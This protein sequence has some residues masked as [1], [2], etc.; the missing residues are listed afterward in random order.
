MNSGLIRLATLLLIL[1]SGADAR[2][3]TGD[4]Y[5]A[6]SIV[7]NQSDQYRGTED[8]LSGIQVSG[9]R[10]MSDHL[11]LEALLGY[12][13]L[14][15][16]CEPG[17]CYPDQKILEASA[18]ALFFWNRKSVLA[19]Y[20]LIGV[21]YQTIGADS[22][23]QYAR[24]AGDGGGSTSLALGLKWRLRGGSYSLRLEQRVRLVF[25]TANLTDT[26]TT[27]GVQYDF[28]RQRPVVAP[29]ANN[30]FIADKDGDFD[31]IPD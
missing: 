12:S 30:D 26:L 3:Q 2:A 23:P 7:F 1:A 16:L 4:W 24:E 21:G 27:L 10:D 6:P 14:K 19:P 9:G 31:R 17:D 20:L 22:G 28:G 18:H 25:D 11:S 13:N 8:S 29:V 5:V 15:G